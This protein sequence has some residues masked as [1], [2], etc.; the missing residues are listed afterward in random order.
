[1]DVVAAIILNQEGQV[2]LARRPAGKHLA[3]LWEFPGG[4]IEPGE[5]P[6][7]ALVRELEEELSLE[8]KIQG[9]LGVFDY[10]YH[11]GPMRL[12][13]FIVRALGTPRLSPDV[14]A[15]E[16]VVAERVTQYDLAPADVEPWRKF[17]ALVRGQ[18]TRA[19]P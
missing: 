7:Q 11:W 3:G 14:A 5:L 16:W 12:H 6:A 15:I 18:S 2:L 1:M 17:R 19:G 10:R 4:K 13:V 9:P 8:V